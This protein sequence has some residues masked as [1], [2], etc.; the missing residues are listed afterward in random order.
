MSNYPEYL[1]FEQAQEVHKHLY[2]N[3]PAVYPFIRR[4]AA[5]ELSKD[6]PEDEG[7]GSSDISIQVTEMLRDYEIPLVGPVVEAYVA[8]GHTVPTEDQFG[9]LL[10][11]LNDEEDSNA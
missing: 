9:P 1:T 5:D 10:Y 11:G 8:C 6:W 4:Y 3:S 7:M 2:E